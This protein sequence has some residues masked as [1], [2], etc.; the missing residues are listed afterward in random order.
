MYL[1]EIGRV[2]AVVAFVE[3]LPVLLLLPVDH[4]CLLNRH[5]FDIYAGIVL[6]LEL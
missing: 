3:P 4:L 1:I 5:H 2:G 6:F